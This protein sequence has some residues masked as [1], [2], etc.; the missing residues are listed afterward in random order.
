MWIIHKRANLRTH[1]NNTNNE[2]ESHNQKLKNF[3]NK[4]MRIPEAIENL[5]LFIDECYTKSSYNRYYNIKTKIYQRNSD[6]E[7]IKYS[8]LCNS[9]S[10][11][12]INEEYHKVDKTK[13]DISESESG[14][15]VKNNVSSYNVFLKMDKCEC[16]K[17]ANFAL[18][19]R[20]IFEPPRG[21]TNNVVS[22]QV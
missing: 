22:E 18:P 15:L 14:Y 1:G 10:F 8:M 11:T 20:H 9:K 3:S 6:S 2:V 21:K 7:I 5:S 19:C 16:L 12:V 4:H 17:Y 13:F